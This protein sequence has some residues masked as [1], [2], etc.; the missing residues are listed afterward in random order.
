M[1]RSRHWTPQEDRELIAMR[2]KSPPAQWELIAARF[3]RT[4][5]A[6]KCHWG[7]LRNGRHESSSQIHKEPVRIETFRAT[8]SA[9]AERE[10]RE[11]AKQKRSFTQVFFGDPAPGYSALDRRKGPLP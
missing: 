2:T 1:T 5:A 4:L 6:C 7:Y 10:A 8:P 11:E 9:I 3:N